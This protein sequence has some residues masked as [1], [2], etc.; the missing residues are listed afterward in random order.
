[1]S[2]VKYDIK[3]EQGSKFELS[4]TWLDDDGDPVN[5]T[6]YTARMMVRDSIDSGSTLFSLTSGAGDIV[7]GGA[8]GTIYVK[9]DA[10]VTAAE[11]FDYGFYDLEVIAAAAEK[12]AI[13]LIE[14]RAR[15]T[16]EI[17]HA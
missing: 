9:I 7:L 3:I 17:T 15:F 16:K 6:G 11:D 14:G 10:D 13:R 8:L 2:A 1:M 4:M 5:L 12:D